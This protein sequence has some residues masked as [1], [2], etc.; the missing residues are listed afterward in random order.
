MD[1]RLSNPCRGPIEALGF[2]IDI[3]PGDVV[4]RCNFATIEDGVV[5]DRRAGRIREHTDKHAESISGIEVAEGIYAYCKPAT[6]HRAVLVLRRQG[7]SDQITD[8]DP[9]AERRQTVSSC[10]A[11]GRYIRST[12]T[13]SAVNR[14]L[15]ISSRILSSQPANEER[16]ANGLLPAS[17]ILT[18]G[19]GSMVELEPIASKMNFRGCCIAA[20]PTLFKWWGL[21]Y[22]IAFVN[23]PLII[24]F[25]YI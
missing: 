21:L 18:R 9:K 3:Q 2:G 17:F 19:A 11:V 4:L 5:L 15:E 1:S 16:V 25:F 8:S 7:L 24:C 10:S 12:T 14:F 13:A 6:E 20:A 23:A 22:R